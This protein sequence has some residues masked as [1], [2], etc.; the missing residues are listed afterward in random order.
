MASTVPQPMVV[1]KIQNYYFQFGAK[2]NTIWKHLAVSVSWNKEK[3]ISTY[4]E[5][6]DIFKHYSWFYRLYVNHRKKEAASLSTVK[7]GYV[8]N[9]NK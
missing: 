8:A 1:A 5:I 3:I 4:P 2:N 7:A 9:V 6:K